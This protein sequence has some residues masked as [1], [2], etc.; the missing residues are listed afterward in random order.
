MALSYLRAALVVLV[1]PPEVDKS[2][3][4]EIRGNS[5]VAS[6]ILRNVPRIDDAV[7]R[8]RDLLAQI[9]DTI[10]G[11]LRYSWRLAEAFNVLSVLPSDFVTEPRI[12]DGV[13]TAATFL[14]NQ[15]S[16]DLWERLLKTLLR[17][18]AAHVNQA[19]GNLLAVTALTSQS[20]TFSFSV[21]ASLATIGCTTFAF[22][23]ANLVLTKC[24]DAKMKQELLKCY[25][26]KLLPSGNDLLLRFTLPKAVDK[27]LNSLVRKFP[28]FYTQC[29][30]A[31]KTKICQAL[32][33]RGK[34]IDYLFMLTIAQQIPN[35]LPRQLHLL[36]LPRLESTNLVF[37]QIVAE[38]LSLFIVTFP[39]TISIAFEY[40]EQRPLWIGSSIL[41]S[42]IVNYLT[43]DKHYISRSL[44]FLDR[45]MK[46]SVTVP[47]ALF[48]ISL[49]LAT[50]SMQLTG[51]GIHLS[52]LTVLFQSLYTNI[53][54][55]P[56]VLHL[57]TDCLCSLIE[58]NSEYLTHLVDN[59]L[60]GV[61]SQLVNSI[62]V[63]PITYSKIAY[64]RSARSIILFAHAI[65]D[66]IAPIE[67][68]ATLSATATLQLT[69]CSTFS[70]YLRFGRLE[71]NGKSIAKTLLLVL[72]KT[73]DS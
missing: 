38:M 21:L 53:A 59:P 25:I 23:A 33:R 11:S 49:F 42:G 12:S 1:Q 34:A 40:I 67:F 36:L 22:D 13:V 6:A 8:T 63:T 10:F 7:L 31:E 56:I 54:L 66:D 3:V 9:P 35:E 2:I 19:E 48:A 57:I 17:F 4:Y 37:V 46:N 44:A 71:M 52:Q 70:D 24:A 69:A 50:H 32:V 41:L 65:A 64:F 20:R 58:L 15:P 27:E 61:V 43:L 60:A 28:Q 55:Q 47:F 14:V 51:L 30:A 5:S 72:Q 18:R 62:K 16:S 73:G 45:N 29:Q 39:E 68:P 26:K